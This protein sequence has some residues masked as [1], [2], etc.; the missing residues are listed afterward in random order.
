MGKLI[1]ISCNA[2]IIAT[3]LGVFISSSNSSVK[4]TFFDLTKLVSLPLLTTSAFLPLRICDDYAG[5]KSLS[6]SSQFRTLLL[7]STRGLRLLQLKT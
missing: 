7:Y 4:N 6:Q 3:R 1:I 5:L 2:Q